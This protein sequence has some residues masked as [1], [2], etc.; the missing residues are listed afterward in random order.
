MDALS[1]PEPTFLSDFSLTNDD[2]R[3]IGRMIGVTW[4]IPD[5]PDLEVLYIKTALKRAGKEQEF[6]E[7]I[8]QALDNKRKLLYS[9]DM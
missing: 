6:E 1:L 8:Q 3:A 7:A 5:N 9:S 4:T 2:I